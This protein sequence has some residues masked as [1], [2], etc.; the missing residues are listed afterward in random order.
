MKKFYL[1]L[2][3]VLA[4]ASCAQVEIE[5]NAPKS[6]EV[7]ELSETTLPG[8]VFDFKVN[9]TK[10]VKNGW[11]EGDKV[12]VFFEG[13]NLGYLTMTYGASGW[14]EPVFYGQAD[15]NSLT[16]SGE[17]L[18]AV[19]LPFGNEA[20]PSYTSAW[21]F[22]KTSYSYY[23]CAEQVPYTVTKAE[24]ITT[25]SATLDMKNPEGYV[26]FFVEDEGA[27]NEGYSLGID[28]VIPT[29]I[30]S[31]ASDGTITETS[32]KSYTDDL[33]GYA[34]SNGSEKGY[35]FS[36]KLNP[37]Y[38][39]KTGGKT[40]Y[41]F[42]KINNSDHSRCDLYVTRS[43]AL[44][45]HDAV[46]LPAHDSDRWLPVGPDKTVFI[47]GPDENYYTCNYGQ[48]VPE[49]LGDVYTFEEANA[50][51]L[52]EGKLL[53]QFTC[54]NVG[55]VANAAWVS[56]HGIKGYVVSSSYGF[57]F[58]PTGASYWSSDKIDSENGY[59]ME[60]YEYGVHQGS[61]PLT[62]KCAV[63]AITKVT[64][65]VINLATVTY[66][67]LT[68]LDGDTLRGTLA[69]EEY[70]VS[71]LDGATITI[72]DIDINGSGAYKSAENAGI[73]CLGD[74]TIILEG[75]NTVKGFLDTY[76]GIYVPEGHTLTITGNGSLDVSCNLGI[77]GRGAGI[78]AGMD[79][80]CGNIIITGGTIN[81]IGSKM[82]AAIGG[83]DEAKCGNITITGGT[84]VAE[85]GCGIGTGEDSSCG[86]IQISGGNIT[87]RSID[88]GAGIGC[89]YSYSLW[90]HC[91][92]ITISG[93]TVDATG[94][95]Y[96]AGIGTANNGRCESITIAS[97][98][99]SVKATKGEDSPNSIGIGAVGDRG[100]APSC[101]T[102]T[103][104]GTEY[105]KNSA[106]VNGGDTNLTQSPLIYPQQ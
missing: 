57:V 18:T 97:T 61:A 53:N 91:G 93:G 3:A 59:T 71:I 30:A 2:C 75:S 32:D 8:I 94:H 103:I 83:A 23:M 1:I 81:A 6:S 79:I 52:G 56:I 21:K 95:E 7:R 15:V 17:K 34:Y 67:D 106:Y 31:I 48:D 33:P 19:Y 58:F 40:P 104:G 60:F 87:A 25:L 80:P 51:N 42:A 89:A 66:Y 96:G 84:I 101:G 76:P 20:T 47:A 26:Q 12:F 78:G 45:S 13:L 35:V 11:E 86:D 49:E 64:K 14:G 50:L 10:A 69:G 44:A 73:T 36:G 68:A 63:R 27:V 90:V 9:M 54:G 65:R 85:G 74:A 77:K 29:G 39:Y 28:A 43:T 88:Y 24:G 4:M 62:Q 41:Y 99:T 37:D 98:V 5:D 16:E 102:I 72:K 22:N 100:G 38:N 105:W 55:N 70:S 46:K 82:G 92:N